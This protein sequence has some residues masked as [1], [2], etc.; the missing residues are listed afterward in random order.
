MDSFRQLLKFIC[1]TCCCCCDYSESYLSI[2]GRRYSIKKLLGESNFSFIYL[3]Q[4]IGSVTASSTPRTNLY[5]LK[6]IRCPFGNIESISG[7]MKEVDNYKRFQSPYI[8]HLVDSQV[9]QQR[10]GSKT[11]YILLPYFP[12][13]S[14]QDS[15]SR[16]L[17][18]GTFI[19]EAECIRIVIGIARGLRCLHDPSAR[20]QDAEQ[21]QEHDAVSMSYSDEAAFLLEDTPLELD[22][23]SSANTINSNF[24]AHRDIKPSNIL[25]S[26]DGLP[27][28]SNLGS[29]SKADL[30]INTGMQLTELQAWVSDHCTVAYTAPELLHI[31][32]NRSVDTKV[33]IWS[34]GC[35]CYF[36][37]F[38]ISPFEREEQI[39]GASL[40]YAIGTGNFSFP[41]Q[42]R[43]SEGLLKL[44]TK[45]LQVNP[46]ARPDI[47][48]LLTL[49]Q[50][51]QES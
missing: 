18:N 11:V 13:G 15:T 8:I 21:Q 26:S 9:A 23:L 17:L 36:M 49:L 12:L 3:V 32:L 6:R 1:G 4:Q 45:C 31:T 43:Y 48:E 42:D 5:A 10:D 7:A 51:L 44:I 2:N 46:A 16:N 39:S 38:G 14:L 24:Y 19:S 22:I 20:S 41:S 47:N 33:D 50:E 34:L 37:L 25:F 27:V 29:C 30:S 40:K 28:I 35:T